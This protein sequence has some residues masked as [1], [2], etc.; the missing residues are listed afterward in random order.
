M[1]LWAN[2]IGLEFARI[3][4]THSPSKIR[5]GETWYGRK[6]AGNPLSSNRRI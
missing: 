4:W 1:N 2:I 5:L 6:E 3:I